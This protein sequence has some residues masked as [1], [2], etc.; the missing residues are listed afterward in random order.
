MQTGHQ[1]HKDSFGTLQSVLLGASTWTLRLYR[2]TQIALPH[3]AKNDVF[4][5]VA[6]LNHDKTLGSP[7]DGF[8][9]HFIP[10]DAVAGGE[11]IAVDYAWGWYTNNDIVPD[12]L[13]NRGTANIA[14]VAGDQYKTKIKNLISTT[15]I[16]PPLVAPSVMTPPVGEGYSSMFWISCTRRNDGTDTYASEIAL[17][18]GDVHYP[19]THL[20]SYNE[21]TD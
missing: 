14:L 6:Q 7:L 12:V 9:I 1:F 10:V 17:V 11:I 13:P 16:I 5:Y 19:T 2:N 21:Y 8:H 4:T 15:E 3:I 18:F 20:G